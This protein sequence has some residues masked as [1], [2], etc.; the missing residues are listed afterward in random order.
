MIDTLSYIGGNLN[1]GKVVWG[2]GASIILNH[3]GIID[4]PNDID[5]LVHLDDIEKADTILSSIGKKKK[6]K[7]TNTYSTK[8]FYEYSLNGTDIDVMSGLRINYENGIFE[9]IFDESSISEIKKI[10][11]VNIPLTSLEDWYVLYQLI[12]NR[13]E[14]VDLIENYLLLNG[15]KQPGLLERSLKRDLPKEVRYKIERL[16]NLHG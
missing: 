8:Y 1:K 13:G 14:K 10:K 12:P 9:Y 6:V 4:K 7:K 16:L 15:I 11:G 5:I 3:H 2:V